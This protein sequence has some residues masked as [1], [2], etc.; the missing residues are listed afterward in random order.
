MSPETL[1]GDLPALM[2]VL[3]ED[4]DLDTESLHS[5]AIFLGNSVAARYPSATWSVM[6]ELRIGPGG[7]GG[8]PLLTII[9]Q[10]QQNATRLTDFMEALERYMTGPGGTSPS[11]TPTLDT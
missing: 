6:D 10:L 1:A 9:T 11:R 5:A 2:K 4:A 8:A 7:V 3:S